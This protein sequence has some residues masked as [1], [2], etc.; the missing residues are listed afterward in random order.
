V[1]SNTP[2]TS[3]LKLVSA[4]P[5]PQRESDRRAKDV[6][7]AVLM[8][9]AQEGDQDAYRRLLVDITPYI[10]AI[11]S[12]RLSNTSDVED[13]L[14]DVLLTVHS[15][16]H[17]Y[18]PGRPFAP[19]I[20]TIANRRA[21]DS[22]RRNIRSQGRHTSLEPIHE[23]FASSEPNIEESVS[24]NDV[25]TKAIAG[26]P[27]KQKEAVTLLKLR[28][29][30][31]KEASAMSGMSVASLKISMHRALKSLRKFVGDESDQA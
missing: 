6:E 8:A 20:A 31:L 17:T 23:T 15:V 3:H 9:R 1:P 2:E 10:R 30:S 4:D 13:A 28:E 16:R 18:D 24:N 27:Q 5:L 29:M 25:L 22:V 7:R 19:W 12:R 11:V 21:I 14:Q 26:L